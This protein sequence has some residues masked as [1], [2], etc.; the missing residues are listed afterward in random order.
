MT[1]TTLQLLE[2]IRSLP[3]Q[4]QLELMDALSPS[5]A[6][7]SRQEDADGFELPV[8]FPE[9]MIKELQRRA[10]AMRDG[11]D[12]G[13]SWEEIRLSAMIAELEQLTDEIDAGSAELYTWKEVRE[14]AP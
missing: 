5:E 6:G 3:R 9:E 12:P 11:T 1:A 7:E 2:V 13:R 4:E 14:Y 10:A 8:H